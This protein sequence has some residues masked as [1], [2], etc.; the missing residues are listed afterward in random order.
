MGPAS[1]VQR[2]VVGSERGRWGCYLSQRIRQ[3]VPLMA[4]T[5]VRARSGGAASPDAA[6]T[7]CRPAAHSLRPAM[8]W[9]ASRA[10]LSPTGSDIAAAPGT[11]GHDNSIT[12]VTAPVNPP[13][14]NG[15][16]SEGAHFRCRDGGVGGAGP[17]P[18]PGRTAIA[19]LAVIN[20]ALEWESC[21][22]LDSR[23]EYSTSG[24]PCAMA[25]ER[26]A[27]VQ[28]GMP[29]PPYR[30][31]LLRGRKEIGHDRAA[32]GANPGTV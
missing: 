7:S 3:S 15:G 20:S 28:P 17:M 30:T 23:R 2:R 32:E 8:Q 26:L 31:M 16:G 21:R 22:A 13:S 10:Y 25:D 19:F 12:G 6:R 27:A 29:A 14:W 4:E 24:A 9:R 1:S 11:T 5:C 18:S